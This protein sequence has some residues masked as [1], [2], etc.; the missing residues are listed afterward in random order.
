MM[1]KLNKLKID[2][3]T[4]NGVYGFNCK[5]VSGVNFIA[6]ESNTCGK[7]SVLEA[8]YYCL[9]F[10][11]IIGGRGEQVLTSVYKNTLIDGEK[12][13]LV[14]ES[15]MYLE[16]SNGE[17]SIT[18]YRA[19]KCQNRKNN[20]ITVYHSDLHNIDLPEVVIEDMYVHMPNAAL[21]QKGFHYFLEQFMG[22]ELPQVQ[23]SDN[24]DRKLYLQ[25]IFSALFIEQKRGW[26]GI[27][28]A[29][30]NLGIK[31]SK[32]RVLEFLLNLDVISTERK[33]L[34]LKQDE[35]EIKK[36]WEVLRREIEVLSEKDD[37]VV[38]G[39]PIKP[40]I[41]NGENLEKVHIYKDF[42]E[43]I[44]VEKYIKDSEVLLE[45]MCVINEEV[46]VNF[47]EL[48]VEL[49]ETEKVIDDIENEIK[50]KKAEIYIERACIKKLENNLEVLDIDIVNNKD[51]D[52]LRRLG[53][54]LNCSSIKGICPVC[55]QEISDS[56]LIDVNINDVMS[57]EDNIKHL[58]AQKKMFDFALKG[59][60]EKKKNL[61]DNICKLERNLY[62]LRRLAKS[63]RTDLYSVDKCVSETIVR[64]RIDLTNSIDK[65]KE[66][67]KILN[68]KLEGFKKISLRWTEYL[69]EKK[70]LP[71]S[72]FS[73]NDELMLKKMKLNFISNLIEFGYKSVNDTDLI[74]ISK[75]TLLP[76]VEGFDMR[77]DSSASDN[78]RAIWAYSIA[79]IQASNEEKGNHPSVIIFDEPD[80]HS[81]EIKHMENFFKSM[82]GLKDTQII[83]GITIK[84][85]NT[86][87]CI[88][89]MNCNT[90][91]II[92]IEGKAFK[93]IED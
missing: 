32:K 84:D 77:F 24:N 44:S 19:A 82:L 21:N 75:D 23:S 51:A 52:K 20:L 76:E 3:R 22:L 70:R 16:I 43:R 25:L 60:N 80:Q 81:I 61:E 67:E 92:N 26:G 9:G 10:E 39:I 8:I 35:L 53:S 74:T 59:H 4:E 7:S 11:E 36:D 85:S 31:D 15:D 18:I 6:S 73:K 33:K 66:L 30:P 41:F 5:F 72:K 17:K 86:R 46:D 58:E 40:Q 56:L 69:S 37:C 87:A 62:T 68:E 55:S 79:L 78:I 83:I 71:S 88:E 57:L 1:L 64:K 54:D 65:Y 45:S 48:Q 12:N 90:Y 63:I 49:T 14:L 34:K 38:I 27:L 13:F 28:S 2:I 47:E 93:K 29:M 89:N 50:E 42:S 91:N